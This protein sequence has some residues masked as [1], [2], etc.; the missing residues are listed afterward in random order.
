[1]RALSP[2]T[3]QVIAMLRNDEDV[4]SVDTAMQCFGVQSTLADENFSVY[5]RIR[6]GMGT[7][8]GSALVV[9]INTTQSP[10]KLEEG[11]WFDTV[12]TG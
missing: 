11:R 9:G 5:D 7:P 4:V 1:M 6:Q 8:M 12:V 3:P 2:L 10:F